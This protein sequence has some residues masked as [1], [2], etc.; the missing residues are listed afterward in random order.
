[1]NK[2]SIIF[3]LLLAAPLLA[4][5]S[6]LAI[7]CTKNEN[8]PIKVIYVDSATQKEVKSAD[9]LAQIKDGKVS[10]QIP[11]IQ[12]YTFANDNDFSY[13]PKTN[14]VIVKVVKQTQVSPTPD[15]PAP[16]PDVPSHNDD[17]S[18]SG[19]TNNQNKDQETKAVNLNLNYLVQS[20]NKNV[21][22][23]K[24]TFLAKI[25]N[26]KVVNTNELPIL[27]DYEI[28]S[29]N[30][31]DYDEKNHAV[32]VYL[33]PKA[34][35]ALNKSDD[36]A[37][38]YMKKMELVIDK[39]ALIAALK[40]QNNYNFNFDYKNNNITMSPR[41]N[42]NEKTIIININNPENYFQVASSTKPTYHNQKYGKDFPSGFMDIIFNEKTN[43]YFLKFKIAEFKS[44][45]IGDIST[46]SYYFDLGKDDSQD[47][48]LIAFNNVSFDYPNKAETLLA[49]ANLDNIIKNVP[50]GY[51][52]IQFEP[53]KVEAKNNVLIKY[54]IKNK[55]SNVES[56]LGTFIIKQWKV[57]AE[58]EN[59]LGVLEDETEAAINKISV[60]YMDEQA[61]NSSRKNNKNDLLPQYFKAKNYDSKK[62]VLN[63]L[64][65]NPETEQIEVSLIN[66][67]NT[68]VVKNK[69]I[70]VSNEYANGLY[71]PHAHT[72]A[73]NTEYLSEKL[74]AAKIYPMYSADAV[75]MIMNNGEAIG[76]SAYYIDNKDPIMKYRLSNFSNVNGELTVT[77]TASFDHWDGSG[78]ITKSKAISLSNKGIDIKN[79][80]DAKNGIPFKADHLPDNT[81]KI[82]APGR[83]QIAMVVY[84]NVS[85]PENAIPRTWMMVQKSTS[86]EP[87]NLSE[88]PVPQGFEL[89]KTNPYRF[90]AEEGKVYVNIVKHVEEDPNRIVEKNLKI[91]LVY[92]GIPKK[93]M[94]FTV[95]I[96]N[97]NI[98]NA[99]DIE[100]P[101]GYILASNNNYSYTDN[102]V[103]KLTFEL[104][105]E[106]KAN[107]TVKYV[108]NTEEKNE[109]AQKQFKATFKNEEK[110]N[111]SNLKDLFKKNVYGYTYAQ[112]NSINK[113]E[114]DAAQ[115]V[116]TIYL[117]KNAE[118]S[119]EKH[120]ISLTFK[121]PNGYKITKKFDALIQDKHIVNKDEIAYPEGYMATSDNTFEV[122]IVDQTALI[123]V[124]PKFAGTTKSMTVIYSVIGEGNTPSNSSLEAHFDT[125]NTISNLNEIAI[126]EGFELANENPYVINKKN[127][128]ITVSIKQK[129][130]AEVIEKSV[131]VKFMLNGGQQSSKSMTLKIQNNKILNKELITAPEGYVLAENNEYTVIDEAGATVKVNIKR[132]TASPS[133]PNTENNTNE[134]I[135]EQ[136][137]KVKYLYKYAPLK[138]QPEITKRLKVDTANKKILNPELIEAPQGYTIQKGNS[139]K[140]D[141]FLNTVSVNLD[142]A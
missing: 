12:G 77:V 97:N 17:N 25:K 133:T 63:L 115:S 107:I 142:K 22:V 39:P 55:Q 46:L 79:K 30:S 45:K 82:S 8:Q 100:M 70:K 18:N 73:E 1:M 42:K 13:E 51:E 138:D 132:P 60:L 116:L 47:Q 5:S 93:S 9:F 114:Y 34:T 64:N 139:F 109:V 43:H 118:A 11:A 117:N 29:D 49:D 121:G 130:S 108:E 61:Y 78:N 127:Y 71:N 65:F 10:N 68:S 84:N 36:V 136:D 35:T 54:R 48:D 135:V 86:F 92:D 110:T 124:E 102:S 137:V 125:E 74:D 23:L 33:A 85:E 76:N 94:H 37:N 69:T 83:T 19:D 20:P 134:S 140:W 52:L 7:S 111:I 53:L 89:D 126:P 75:N 113:Y 99:E 119:N 59:N 50:E 6:T 66:N 112:D 41:S 91:D 24:T 104:V 105:K 62:F 4:A 31:Y 95:K 123:S 122:D 3:R 141:K 67:K 131:I 56:N 32:N 21:S 26:S 27:D 80:L 38:A 88:V 14:R 2:K 40:Q 72:D 57:N 16:T 120:T 15:T 96:Q 101:L 44:Y 90:I 81:Q 98:I 87:T 28:K 129:Q 128:N 103:E 58:N 106:P